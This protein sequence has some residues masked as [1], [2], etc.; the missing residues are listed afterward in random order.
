MNRD[1]HNSARGFTMVEMVIVIVVIGAIFGL[2]A[3]VMG[4]AFESYVLARESTDVDWQGRV[5]LE[6]MVRELREIRAAT[7]VDLSPAATQIRFIDA[8]G[9][10]VCFYHDGGTRLMRSADG[11]LSACGTTA[12]QP[13]ADNIPAG[14]LN[15]VYYTSAG[16]ATLGPTFVFY[17]SFT[18]NVVE[19]AI[20]ETYRTTVQPRRF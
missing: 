1:R 16:A 4:R 11:P 17:I 3:L 12:P 7:A 9:N 18:L 19:G 14:G 2:G 8:G 15:F 10:G 5:A 13:L 20:T 6:R